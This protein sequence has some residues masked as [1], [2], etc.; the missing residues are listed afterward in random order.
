ML[1]FQENVSLAPFTTFRIGGPARYFV[2]VENLEELKVALK[3][4][5]E[6]SWPIFIL[7]G[8]SNLIISSAGFAGLVIHIQMVSC[9]VEEQHII[10]GAGTQMATVVD[11]SI[12]AGLAGLE[13]AG[14][15]PGTLGGAIRGNAGA[16]GGEIKDVVEAVSSVDYQSGELI[17]RKNDECQFSYRGSIFKQNAHEVIVSAS[18]I[19]KPGNK[20]HLRQI[21]NDHIHYRQHRHPLELPNAGS[22]FKNT[23]VEKIPAHILPQ[24]KEVIKDDP[25]PV[26]PTAKIIADSGCA[27]LTIGGSQVSTRHTNYIVNLGTGTGEEIL[28]LINAVKARVR[29][30][31]GIE[32]EVEPE[33]V[34]FGPVDH[35]AAAVL[36]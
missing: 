23:P 31:F 19:L 6:S 7:A 21:A 2:S 35:A 15:L 26:V 11:A 28:Q 27:G 32:L 29:D 22:I 36:K 30:K 10:S 1:T 34:G 14:G 25:F 16:F 9:G 12:E 5:M 4:A 8:G 24:F 13:W 3:K 20:E 18:L 17:N 33:L